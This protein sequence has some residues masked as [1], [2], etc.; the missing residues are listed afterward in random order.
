MNTSHKPKR[1][2]IPFTAAD[3]GECLR[4]PLARGRGDAVM[5]ADDLPLLR[6]A[7]LTDGW[8]F[9]RAGN[10]RFRYVR[11]HLSGGNTV[12]V[13]R[14]IAGAPTGWHVRYHDGNPSN[15]RRGN[16]YLIEGRAKMDC[17]ALVAEQPA[18][19]PKGLPLISARAS[20]SMGRSHPP[21]RG[22]RA[23]PPADAKAIRGQA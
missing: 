3:G 21:L 9:N 16:L 5:D 7:G 23:T 4:V 11:A 14:V 18:D 17:A 8:S 19:Q 20:E 22:P 1:Q 2:P 6:Q 12:T 10:A 15:L 13:A